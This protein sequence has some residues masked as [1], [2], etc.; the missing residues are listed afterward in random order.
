MMPLWTTTIFPVQSRCG[1]AFSSVGAVRR[2]ARVSDAV[3]AGNRIG[4]NHVLEIRQLAGAATQ[5]DDA[6]TDDGDAGES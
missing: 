2:P 1:W 3:V 6:V 5:V 4:V